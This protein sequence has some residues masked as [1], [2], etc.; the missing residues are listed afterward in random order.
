MHEFGVTESVVAAVRERLPDVTVTCVHL[1]IGTLSG[2]AADSVRFY[3]GPATGGTNLEGARLESREVPARCRC[4]RLT[5]STWH[6]SNSCASG[7]A[8]WHSRPTM[9][10]SRVP[11]RR[12]AFNWRTSENLLTSSPCEAGIVRASIGVTT[13]LR[14]QRERGTQQRIAQR[15]EAGRSALAAE[16][17]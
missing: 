1:E 8:T 14:P 15:L 10:G 4:G 6:R 9:P 16:A 5:P 13:G 3:F 7:S 2:G 11:P 17:S 12:S